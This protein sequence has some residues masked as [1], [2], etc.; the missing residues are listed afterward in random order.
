MQKAYHSGQY[1]VTVTASQTSYSNIVVM[2]TS[3]SWHSGTCKIIC[4]LQ[5][6]SISTVPTHLPRFV[7]LVIS[8]SV[9]PPCYSNLSLAQTRPASVSP[10]PSP[11]TVPQRPSTHTST[12]PS[13]YKDSLSLISDSHSSR[14]A[15]ITASWINH[16]FSLVGKKTT[17]HRMCCVCPAIS[18]DIDPKVIFPMAI[19]SSLFLDLLD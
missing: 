15:L 19:N 4:S 13:L 7:S 1:S 10:H 8:T 6:T 9:I 5:I 14:L 2:R 3:Y 11:P 17:G 18:G 16:L 12:V